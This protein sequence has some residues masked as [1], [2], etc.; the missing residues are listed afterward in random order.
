MSDPC[1]CSWGAP[2]GDPCDPCEAPTPLI[3]ALERAEKAEAECARL[4]D[5]RDTLARELD[6]MRSRLVIAGGE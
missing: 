3:V 1:T 2:H 5:E 6:A 4:R